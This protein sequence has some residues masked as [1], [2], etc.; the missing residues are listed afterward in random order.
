MADSARHLHELPQ[1]STFRFQGQ[2]QRFTVL[3][4][5]DIR[6]LIAPARAPQAREVSF[7]TRFGA[8]VSFQQMGPAGRPCAGVALVE[9]LEG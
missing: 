3:E 7:A 9:P 6:P 4:S 1:H 8:E 2:T 5:N